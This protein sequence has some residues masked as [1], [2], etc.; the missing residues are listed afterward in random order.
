MAK[1]FTLEQK[2]LAVEAAEKLG[3]KK[4]A[5]IFGCST[6]AINFWKKGEC[7]GGNQTRKFPEGVRKGIAE[8][9]RETGKSVSALA[10]LF[11]VDDG[12]VQ[13]CLRDYPDS[14][15]SLPLI[16][17]IEQP[18]PSEEKS[19]LVPLLESILNTLKGF[20]TTYFE[21]TEM[22][23]ATLSKLLEAVEKLDEKLTDK[24]KELSQPPVQSF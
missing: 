7:L 5:T 11:G 9:A 21:Q 6:G 8:I 4:A 1:N 17:K 18:E 3:M 20:E 22:I 15:E 2:R 14:S 19:D 23:D 16:E 24:E 13:R 10:K 12:T